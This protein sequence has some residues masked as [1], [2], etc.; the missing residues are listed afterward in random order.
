MCGFSVSALCFPMILT[1]LFA[2]TRLF[3]ALGVL[4]LVGVGL[5]AALAVSKKATRET[6]P[7]VA[8]K[9]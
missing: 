5:V 8:S 3:V 6:A 1:R 2:G 4:C 7:G 9:T